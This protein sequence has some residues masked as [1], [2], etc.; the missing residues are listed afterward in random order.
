MRVGIVGI[1]NMGFAMA[2]R[3]YE[4]GFALAVRDIDTRRERDAAGLGMTVCAS[5]AELAAQS[6]CVIV[7]SSTQSRSTT[8]C[9]ATPV[10]LLHRH[11]RHAA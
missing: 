6:D 9:S 1:G 2:E 7:P 3:L 5:P 8:C 10:W 4:R 11:A